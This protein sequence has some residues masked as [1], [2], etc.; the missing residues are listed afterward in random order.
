MRGRQFYFSLEAKGSQPLL[1]A[2]TCFCESLLGQED[3]QSLIQSLSTEAKTIL[4]LD[5]FVL[6]KLGTESALKVKR[7]ALSS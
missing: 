1:E 7:L 6:E 4:N 2:E 5:M 3:W